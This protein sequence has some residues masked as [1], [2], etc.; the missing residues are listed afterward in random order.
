MIMPSIKPIHNPAAQMLDH[1]KECV[2]AWGSRDDYALALEIRAAKWLK[3]KK[4]IQNRK[5]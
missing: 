3:K 4:A 5:A 1:G 2:P